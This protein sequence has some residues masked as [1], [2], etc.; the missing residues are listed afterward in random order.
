MQPPAGQER[1]QPGCAQDELSKEHAAEQP[2]GP[3]AGLAGAHRIEQHSG[4]GGGVPGHQERLQS[5]H[6]RDKALQHEHGH[7]HMPAHGKQRTEQRGEHG[8]LRQGAGKAPGPGPL[9]ALL[10][11]VPGGHGCKDGHSTEDGSRAA[12]GLFEP[13]PQHDQPP[14]RVQPFCNAAGQT[15]A[16]ARRFQ[17]AWQQG[18]ARRA[19]KAERKSRVAPRAGRALPAADRRSGQA[20]FR[21]IAELSA[22]RTRRQKSVRSYQNPPGIAV[23]VR[24][25]DPWR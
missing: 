24:R 5:A 3:L 17:A 23:W 16:T 21:P 12:P 14:D 8:R 20:R 22:S 10:E 6:G 13:A 15:A 7:G 18:K 11:G 1:C 2:P 9:P 25:H 19:C 4:H